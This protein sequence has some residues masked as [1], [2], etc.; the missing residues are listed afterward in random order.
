[1]PRGVTSWPREVTLFCAV[2]Q[3]EVIDLIRPEKDRQN[4]IGAVKLSLTSRRFFGC[5]FV[6]CVG[7]VV[8]WCGLRC[9]WYSCL[10]CPPLPIVSFHGIHRRVKCNHFIISRQFHCNWK[11]AGFEFELI[12]DCKVVRFCGLSHICFCQINLF[13]R[14]GNLSN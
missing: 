2:L 11:S 6:R 3:A 4:N 14:S 10:L 5:Q 12:L 9:E 1:M 7:E 8:V 13:I